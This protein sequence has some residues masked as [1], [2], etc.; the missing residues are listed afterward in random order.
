M[1]NFEYKNI[2]EILST[3]APTRGI[4]I[5]LVKDTKVIVPKFNQYNPSITGNGIENVELHLDIL[6]AYI[7]HI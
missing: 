5:D 1:A 2:D 7:I 4:R 6:I 3:N